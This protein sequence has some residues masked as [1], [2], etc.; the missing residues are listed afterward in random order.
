ML[1]PDPRRVITRLFVPGDEQLIHGQSRVN[2]VIERIME[3]DAAAASA[4]LDK[5]LALFEDR[6]DDL[7]SVLLDN[8]DLVAH[9]LSGTADVPKAVR[10][11]VGAYFTHEYSLESAALFNPSIVEHPDQRGIPAEELRVVL[12]VRAV[13]EGHRSAIEFRTGVVGVDGH[14]RLDRP[15]RHITAGRGVESRYDRDQFYRVLSELGDDAEDAAFVIDSLPDR[16]T[17]VELED[18]LA[19]LHGQR[20]T[21]HTADRTIE[22]L[23]WFA[24]CN[25]EVTYPADTL[26]DQRVLMPRAPSESNGMEDA[27][28]VRFVDDDGT[29]TYRATYRVR[30]EPSDATTPEH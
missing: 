19:T 30:R 24:A 11:L 9:R 22:H 28:F 25:Y 20:L 15:D 12:S 10:L 16:F 6:H 17:P 29:V 18:L 7:P 27:R 2:P 1:R 13:G 14:L 21:R 4:A 5:T 23:R 3:L 8:F 26:L